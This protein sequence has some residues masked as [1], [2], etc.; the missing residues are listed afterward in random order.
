MSFEVDNCSILCINGVKSNK[1]RVLLLILIY[2]YIKKEY[3]ISNY[4]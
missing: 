2:D 4:N 3:V 1:P